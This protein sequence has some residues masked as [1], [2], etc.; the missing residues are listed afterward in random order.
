MDPASVFSAI[1]AGD[2]WTGG[3][4]PGSRP[5]FCRPLVRWLTNYIRD[6]DIGSLCDLGCGDFQWM[7]DVLRATGIDYTGLDVYGPLISRHRAA[8]REYRFCELAVSVAELGRIPE[9]GLYWCKDVL[10]HWPSG[11]IS[12]FLGGFFAARP[13]ARLLVC[14][15]AGQT[16]DV[17][18]LDD[19]WHFAPL[20]GTRPPLSAFRPVLLFAWGGK[21][22]YSLSTSARQAA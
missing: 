1:Y 4:G 13:A 16:S 19:R 8:Y 21:H 11:T 7:P 12:D 5:G 17:R 6:N 14:N 18:T 2:R 15:C 9:A 20:D 3:S 22:V 10:Q